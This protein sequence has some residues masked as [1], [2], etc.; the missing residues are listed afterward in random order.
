MSELV[1]LTESTVQFTPPSYCPTLASVHLFSFP[2]PSELTNQPPHPHPSSCCKTWQH[3]SPLHLHRAH[4][5]AMLLILRSPMCTHITICNPAPPPFPSL[6][7]CLSGS[8]SYFQLHERAIFSISRENRKCSAGGRHRC[9]LVGEVS[10]WVPGCVYSQLHG[11]NQPDAPRGDER[12]GA[13]VS[14]SHYCFMLHKM[15]MKK[16]EEGG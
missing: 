4:L 11:S 6:S 5:S 16:E 2:F 15:S 7:L 14:Q 8:S 1:C 12:A 9:V 3:D 10:H 13:A